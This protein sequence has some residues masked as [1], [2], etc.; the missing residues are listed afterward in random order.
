MKEFITNL[1]LFVVFCIAFS[2]LTA[3]TGSS[4]GNE[5]LAGAPA[6]GN[7]ASGSTNSAYPPVSSGIA[8][9]E[10]V[11]L[12]GTKT[13]LSDRKGKV[14]ILNLWGI[15]CGPCRDEMPHL[16]AMQKKYGDKGLEVIGLNIGDYEGKAE[17]VEA[18]KRFAEQMKIDYTLARVTAPIVNQIY[19]L[20]KQQVVPQTLLVDREGRLRGVFV[21]GGQRVYDQLQQ[22]LDKTMNEPVSTSQP[23]TEVRTSGDDEGAKM[24]LKK[25]DWVKDVYVSPGY[26]NV[27]VIRGE[28]KWDSP[29]IGNAVCGILK[30]FGSNLTSVRFVDIEEVA[31]Q[32][33]SPRQAEI[34]SMQCP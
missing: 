28:K 8:E 7:S 31:D 6:K 12:D 15:W 22:T 9:G 17:S 19:L 23:P 10:I 29:M 2:S 26:M 5:N 27:G 16:Q 33:K 11:L 13:K 18:I 20:T 4:P 21:G 25:L 1:A 14:V 24:E 34:Y 30:R 32:Q 3:C